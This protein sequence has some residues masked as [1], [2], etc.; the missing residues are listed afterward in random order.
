MKRQHAASVLALVMVGSLVTACSGSD[1]SEPATDLTKAAEGWCLDVADDVGTEISKLPTVDCN[2]PH[3]HEVFAV[4]ESSAD[5]YPGFEALEKEA[6]VKCLEKFEPY[7]GISPFDSKLFY[8]WMVP[9]LASWEDPDVGERG[10]R[11]II[12]VVGADNGE[13]LK[14]SVRGSGR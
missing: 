1:G 8:S 5:A 3:T 10:D 11:E 7:V 13:I 6:Q 9:T 2:V 12:C 14:E 4:I